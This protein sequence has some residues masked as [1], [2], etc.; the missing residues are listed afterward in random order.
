MDHGS[1]CGRSDLL[2]GGDMSNKHPYP[3]TQPFFVDSGDNL[4]DVLSKMA[5]ISFQGRTLG[6]ALN[7]WERAVRRGARIFLGLS[8][9]M[10]P[11]GMRMILVHLI[12][13]SLINC[14]VTTG[15]N[16]FHDLHESLGY[17]HFI[18]TP[19]TDDVELRRNR[20]DR[21]YDTLADDTEFEQVDQFVMGVIE[22]KGLGGRTFGTPEFFKILG[23]AVAEREHRPG[24]VV[25][26]A[27]RDVPVFCPAIGDSSIGIAAAV[28]A[29]RKPEYK[30]GFDVVGDVL[31]LTEL[32][33][34]VEETG[35]VFIG[36]GTPKNFTQ[37]TE[38]VSYLLGHEASGHRYCVQFATDAP[39]W[40]GLSGCTFEES[41]SWGKIHTEADMVNVYVDATIALPIVVTALTQ[42]LGIE[43]DNV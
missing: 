33:D 18:G 2:V 42:R 41:Q 11:A 1:C 23:M 34:E 36:G 6:M 9:A 20:M 24:F 3:P 21:M 19:F 4:N 29:S 13:H 17:D 43:T 40:G 22:S 26:A 16:T 7:I 14:I 5:N 15:A 25:E 32:V 30:V 28:L 12:R 27:E 8:G 39:H 31:H 37:Q 38:V 10:V 35:V